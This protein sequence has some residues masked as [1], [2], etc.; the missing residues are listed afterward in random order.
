MFYFVNVGNVIT[1]PRR[2][3]Y[4]TLEL[5]SPKRV[6]STLPNLVEFHPAPDRCHELDSCR[7]PNLKTQE[8]LTELHPAR[9]VLSCVRGWGIILLQSHFHH[10]TTIYSTYQTW[11]AVFHGV[12]TF[13]NHTA[14]NQSYLSP[15]FQ[16]FPNTTQFILTTPLPIWIAYQ[17]LPDWPP[18]ED[19]LTG[20]ENIGTS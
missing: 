13:L 11:H 10:L 8:C 6:S 18:Y 15:V 16:A 9:P 5:N 14:D 7:S 4:Q 3:R 2:R 17:L 20:L 1:S 19:S 12:R